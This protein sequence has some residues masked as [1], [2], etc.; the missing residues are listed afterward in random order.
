MEPTP[1]WTHLGMTLLACGVLAAAWPDLKLDSNA[2]GKMFLVVAL[3]IMAECGLIW[4]EHKLNPQ[5]PPNRNEE[6]EK[7]RNVAIV[8]RTSSPHL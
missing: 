1:G 2:M 8:V 7:M 4:V 5:L 3:L 6:P